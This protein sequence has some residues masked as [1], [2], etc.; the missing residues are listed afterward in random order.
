[1]DA[2]NRERAETDDVARMRNIIKPEHRCTRILGRLARLPKD[3]RARMGRLGGMASV[4]SERAHR[5]T[6]ATARAASLK[7]VAKRQASD[8]RPTRHDEGKAPGSA[9]N[10]S[11]SSVPSGRSP[12]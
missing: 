7:A 9:L 12:R 4:G 10:F 2:G 1:M 11:S 3:E 8:A 5:W 6:A